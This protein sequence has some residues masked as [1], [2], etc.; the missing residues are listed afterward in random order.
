MTAAKISSWGVFFVIFF[1]ILREGFE[2][3][4]FLITSF[5]ITESFSYV[6]FFLGAV[7][8]ILLGYLVVVQGKRINLKK[9]FQGTTLLL[10]FLASGMVAYGTHEV[11]SYLVKSDQLEKET[12]SRPWDILQPKSELSDGENK[13]FYSYDESKNVYTHLLHDSGSVGVFLKGFFGY[14][15]NPNYIELI[16]WFLSLI[17]GLNLWR[18][19]YY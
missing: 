11:E 19:F 1:A 8:A 10:V 3:V 13:F 16:M 7:L 14:N 15:S 6:G 17:F 4:V 12:I 2:T 18:R 5:S 9:F